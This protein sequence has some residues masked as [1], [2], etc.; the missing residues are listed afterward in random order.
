MA[1]FSVYAELGQAR[2]RIMNEKLAKMRSKCQIF[3]TLRVRVSIFSEIK[4]FIKLKEIPTNG[5]N[6]CM[7]IAPNDLLILQM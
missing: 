4:Q 7:E 2:V 6:R 5:F 1:R 3:T